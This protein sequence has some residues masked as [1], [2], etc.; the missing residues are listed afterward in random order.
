MF[1]TSSTLRSPLTRSQHPSTQVH[2]PRL[3]E[4]GKHEW[5][6]YRLFRLLPAGRLREGESGQLDPGNVG[7]SLSAGSSP[8]HDVQRPS[9]R[10]QRTRSRPVQSR[11]GHHHPVRGGGAG[12]S[13]QPGCKGHLLLLHSH[14]VERAQRRGSAV[15]ALLPAGEFLHVCQDFYVFV[16]KI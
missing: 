1:C 16:G 12:A 10:S 13:E 14:R 11:P 15:Q 4:S 2:H 8:R 6:C 5:A 9:C 3:G 7:R